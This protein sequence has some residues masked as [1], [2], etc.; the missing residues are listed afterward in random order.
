MS[1][2]SGIKEGPLCGT[3]QEMTSEVTGSEVCGSVVERLPGVQEA[4]SLVLSTANMK[5]LHTHI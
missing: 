5:I 2:G 4:L 1:T 3:F